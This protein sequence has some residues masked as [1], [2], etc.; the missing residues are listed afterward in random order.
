VTE[1]AK[2]AAKEMGHVSSRFTFD[3]YE[4]AT[5]MREWLQGNELPEFDRAREWAEWAQTGTN[6]ASAEVAFTSEETEIRAS[7]DFLME[8]TG[9]EPVT[10]GLQSRRSP[11]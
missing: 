2:R 10:S 3:C 9:I 6:S 7:R 1:P 11:S 8:R 4:Q 5:D